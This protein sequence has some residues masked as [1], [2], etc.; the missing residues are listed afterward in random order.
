MKSLAVALA[1][2]VFLQAIEMA[3]L[4]KRSMY[5]NIDSLP[6]LFEGSLDI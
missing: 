5:K 3:I 4:E 2:M 6:F 1:E